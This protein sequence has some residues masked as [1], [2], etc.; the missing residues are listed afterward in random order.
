MVQRSGGQTDLA[1][2]PDIVAVLCAAAAQAL[3][4]GQLAG[5]G[6]V[7][8]EVAF[9]GVAADEGNAV[10]AQHGEKAT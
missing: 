8:N 5:D 1:R 2:Y 3:A 7:E 6:N 4:R 10:L 9:G